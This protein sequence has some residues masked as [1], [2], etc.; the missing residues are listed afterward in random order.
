MQI[1]N[2]ELEKKL[3]KREVSSLN[4][5]LSETAGELVKLKAGES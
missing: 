5:E 3:L 2:L 1:S 4:E